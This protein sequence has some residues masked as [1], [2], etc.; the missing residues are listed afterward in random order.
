MDDLSSQGSNITHDPAACVNTSRVN[1]RDTVEQL[2]FPQLEFFSLP[3]K[4][5]RD[6]YLHEL[7]GALFP[8]RPS[9]TD[10]ISLK[11]I[12]QVELGQSHERLLLQG[13]IRSLHEILAEQQI[14]FTMLI[15]FSDDGVKVKK[16]AFCKN[17]DR[18]KCQV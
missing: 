6:N 15:R 18:S 2:V 12:A 8:L 3:I 14:A 16:K 10:I 11:E 5:S 1:I 4:F 7:S 13:E 17:A 9:C